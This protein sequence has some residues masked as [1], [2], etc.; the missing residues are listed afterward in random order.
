MFILEISNLN[1]SSFPTPFLR[2]FCALITQPPL[3]TPMGPIKIHRILAPVK[4]LLFIT[5]F[6]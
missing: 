1:F 5:L 2:L 6:Y 4:I 3:K